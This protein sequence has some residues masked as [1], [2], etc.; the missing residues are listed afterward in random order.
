[1]ISSGL[2][3]K[4]LIRGLV[5]GLVL[6]VLAGA[7]S[8]SPGRLL[9]WE[10][11]FAG[12]LDLSNHSGSTRLT[13]QWALEV[14]EHDLWSSHAG[15][16]VRRASGRPTFWEI[17]PGGWGSTRFTPESVSVSL[18]MHKDNFTPHFSQVGWDGLIVESSIDDFNVVYDDDEVLHISYSEGSV[19]SG[20]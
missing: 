5:P 16:S 2:G 18:Q 13:G 11:D 8:A 17:S 10:G 7:A 12:D 3:G 19:P 4:R 14:H 20:R 1:M 15:S 9:R 6:L